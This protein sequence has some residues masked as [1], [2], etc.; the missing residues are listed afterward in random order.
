MLQA[1]LIRL[2]QRMFLC[3]AAS[4]DGQ[5][6]LTPILLNLLSTASESIC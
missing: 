2:P 6:L 4:S 5:A 1:K 3:G